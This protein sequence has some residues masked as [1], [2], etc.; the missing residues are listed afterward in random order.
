MERPMEPA[1]ILKTSTALLALGALGGLLMAGMRFAGRPHPPPSLAM[2][3]GLLA[4][5]ALTL[6]IYAAATVGLPPLAI[7]ALVL[8]LIAAAGG[9]VLNLNYQHWPRQS[10]STSWRG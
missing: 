2:L 3:H 5:A 6:L 8:F 9:T 4:G 7:A 1:L 10:P